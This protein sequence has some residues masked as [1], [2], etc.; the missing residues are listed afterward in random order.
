MSETVQWILWGVS[1]VITIIAFLIPL[2]KTK[3]NNKLLQ[4]SLSVLHESNKSLAAKVSELTT[5]AEIMEFHEKLK[6]E[7]LQAMQA[8]IMLKDIERKPKIKKSLAEAFGIDTTQEIT[9]REGWEYF[10]N[11]RVDR[12]AGASQKNITSNDKH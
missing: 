7:I 8:E 5:K 4:S 10:I 12:R 9:A 2:I 3:R 11:W 6:V 1:L